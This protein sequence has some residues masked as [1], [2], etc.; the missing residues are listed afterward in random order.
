VIEVGE[1]AACI[2]QNNPN[3]DE[4]ILRPR[5]QGLSGKAKFVRLL[6]ARSFDL[7]VILDLSADMRLYLWMGGV[8]RRVGLVRK[9]R[10][11][12][13]LTD[14][15]EYDYNAH[16]MIDN[17]RRVVAHLGA[18]VS[19][20]TTDLYIGEDIVCA[21]DGML[22][23][24]GICSDETLIGLNVGAS[25]QPKHWPA[26]YFAELGNR[27]SQQVNLRVILLGGPLEA[28]LAESIAAAMDKPPSIF[29]GI[30]VLEQ[31]E[32]Q[33]RCAVVVTAD[34]GPMHLACATRTR[35]VALFGPTNPRDYGPD[36]VPG[37][38]I[39]RKT[40]GCS[41]CC[42]ERCVHANRCMHAISVDEV[43]EAVLSVLM[44]AGRRAQEPRPY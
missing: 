43:A 2:L 1:R 8:R 15:V 6:R 24:A 11:A 34:T 37:N 13:T 32:L 16:E 19:D 42:W 12:K 40:D 44:S 9:K 3:V 17:F 30:K 23:G 28:A 14:P 10:F 33:R 31:A 5:H 26:E 4:I 41:D 38:I 20:S 36:Y 35:V 25:T 21:V 27:L 39:I 22:I 7:G 29:T 18:D